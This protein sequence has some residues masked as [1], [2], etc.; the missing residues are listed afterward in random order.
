MKKAGYQ[1]H[2]R[3]GQI[4]FSE[5]YEMLDPFV[6]EFHAQLLSLSR[7][8]DSQLGLEKVAQIGNYIVKGVIWKAFDSSEA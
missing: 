1:S 3:I 7:L 8:R 6:D 2:E 5:A 4:E